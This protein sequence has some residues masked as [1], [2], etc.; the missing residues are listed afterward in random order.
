[1]TKTLSEVFAEAG[2]ETW[3]TGG[4]CEA[5]RKEIPNK[6]HILI[7]DDDG[8]GLPTSETESCIV[9]LYD[10]EGQPLTEGDTVD[11]VESAITAAARLQANIDNLTA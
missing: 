11:S 2:F 10:T 3:S 5:W 7:T 6:G 4:G 9:G 8:C 1:M